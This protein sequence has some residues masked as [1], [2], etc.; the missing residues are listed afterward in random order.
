M[1]NKGYSTRV[2]KRRYC[3]PCMCTYCR[4]QQQCVCSAESGKSDS[5][6]NDPQ[7][8][9]VAFPRC[10]VQLLL[11]LHFNSNNRARTRANMSTNRV[12]LAIIGAGIF[13]TGTSCAT[14]TR[15]YTQRTP[16]ILTQQCDL[17]FRA[18]RTRTTAHSPAHLAHA[19]S[20][21]LHR[22]CLVH[23]AIFSLT[24]ERH[25]PAL[26]GLQNI[27]EVKAGVCLCMRLSLLLTSFTSPPSLLSSQF[28]V[29]HKQV[30]RK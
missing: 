13:V 5:A 19:C 21:H 2:T 30:R 29:E 3:Y 24:P 14:N 16:Q 7:C 6:H 17:A 15:T 8:H 9:G 20:S 4:S 28:T 27:V 11:F 22:A 12:R 1:A 25:V 23:T 10:V 26:S 18:H